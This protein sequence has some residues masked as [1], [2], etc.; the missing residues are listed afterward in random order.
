[1]KNVF[2]LLVLL[3]FSIVIQ[4]CSNE[5]P[6]PEI[7]IYESDAF[8][9]TNY[10]VKQGSYS[11][12][13]VNDSSI[14]SNYFNEPRDLKF[15]FAINGLDNEMGFGI[16]H[17][18]II[19]PDS[20]GTFQ[21]PVI[22]F[23][24]QQIQNTPDESKPF[25]LE[26]N[27]KV[28]FQV[29][30][31]PVFDEITKNGMYQGANGHQI[32][33]VSS[34]SVLGSKPP[35]DWDF[36]GKHNELKDSDGDGIY[37]LTLTFNPIKVENGN[38][39]WQLSNDISKYAAFS[40]SNL[41]LLD[42]LYNLSLEELEKLR[43]T[44]GYWDTGAKWSGVWTRDMSYSILLSL[45]YLDPETAKQCLRKKVTNDGRIIQDTGT[46]GSWPVSS[47]RMTWSLAAWEIW[48]VTGDLN[49][50]KEVYPIL[51]KSVRDDLENVYST[52]SLIYGETSF[53]D[54][55]EQSY[56]RWMKPV[57]IYTS[58]AADNSMVHFRTWE[59]LSKMAYLMN[60]ESVQF[61]F[62]KRA[63][64]LKN[65]INDTFWQSENEYYAQFT[66]GRG[67]HTVSPRSMALAE[68]FSI[69]FDVASKQ[70][71]MRV[72]AKTPV[73]KW[74]IPTFYPQIPHISSYHNNG[75]WPFVQAFWNVSLA[76]VQHEEA[77]TFGLASIWRA[78]TLF[79]TNKENMRA[80]NG[81]DFPTE[82]NS[83]RQ[84]WSVAGNLAMY[85]RIFF[86]MDFQADGLHLNPVIPQKFTGEKSLKNFT[87]RK[88]NIS[89]KV[90]GFG[91]Q[92]AT[93]TINGKPAEK[94]FIPADATGEFTIEIQMNNTTFGKGEFAL[95]KNEYSLDTPVVE[96]TPKGLKWNHIEGAVGYELFKNGISIRQTTD[97]LYSVEED[98]HFVEW[99]VRA[100]HPNPI[101][102]SFLSEP[103]EKIKK[104]SE[105][106]AEIEWFG[107]YTRKG[108]KN[109]RGYG[110][111]KSSH[112]NKETASVTFTV[113]PPTAGAY[114]LHFRY[115][116]GNGPINTENKAAIRTLK[117][118]DEQIAAVVFPQR[119]IDAWDDW[120]M[121]NSL[122]VSLKTGKNKIELIYEPFNANMNGEVNEFWIDAL[123]LVKI[124]Q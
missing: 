11:A 27:V 76:K 60:E 28:T 36:A 66:Y 35:L 17:T 68:S 54:W 12:R 7:P 99:Q 8:T 95:Q 86:G 77:L 57:D 98:R 88:A 89:V 59:I 75:I 45:A 10:G 78:A 53:A 21:T 85:Y 109:F 42:A 40:T 83:D 14:I 90:F 23:G 63:V 1:M 69:L 19:Y 81:N 39:K 3:F 29:D 65:R 71:Q 123:R 22:S 34:I 104:A 9:L 101:L 50:I 80:D 6:L 118:N 52:D 38:R 102:N 20:M 31:N 115:A 107:S 103:V 74:G 121:S 33:G 116:N 4:S 2:I 67:Y 120:G 55:R 61:E 117:I 37:E 100:V 110:F 46:G 32:K 124:E 84:L 108:A 113:Y 92:I 16:D 25:F 114:W 72:A 82:I 64:E 18:F 62:E 58:E 96:A 73:V 5:K 106:W 79:L 94:A 47:D 56:P 41:P 97:T 44:D 122:E 112:K 119:G 13:V 87:Y 91:N 30:L 43:T 51:L 49:W 70:N 26:P 48:N 111:L 15:K 24:K 105:I 93:C